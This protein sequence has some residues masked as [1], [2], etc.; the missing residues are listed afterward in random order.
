MP[1][2]A[3]R[4]GWSVKPQQ[5]G[6]VLQCTPFHRAYIGGQCV[7]RIANCWKLNKA[8]LLASLMCFADRRVLFSVLFYSIISSGY[9]F[10]CLGYSLATGLFFS[11]RAIVLAT[12]LLLQ[13][14][15]YSFSF[16]CFGY[17]FR[18]CGSLFC[19]REFWLGFWV[20]AVLVRAVC[21]FFAAPNKQKDCANDR[22]E[23][24]EVVPAAFVDIVESSYG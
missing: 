13:P 3:C 14:P 5:K 1:Y 2:R 22:D 19:C 12:G 11:Y 8:D 6:Q 7:K 15:G 16:R 23:D 10:N 21:A 4:M 24:Q 18:C 17:S 9:S 20:F